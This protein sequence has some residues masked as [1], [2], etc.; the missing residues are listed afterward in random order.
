MLTEVDLC[1]R[2][3]QRDADNFKRDVVDSEKCI[4]NPDQYQ[5]EK[6][7]KY[8]K[9]KIYDQ[10]SALDRLRLLN[11]TF[12][13]KKRRLKSH[14]NQKEDTSIQFIKYHEVC[15]YLNNGLSDQD[16]RVCWNCWL[17]MIALYRFLIADAT[18]AKGKQETAHR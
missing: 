4:Y 13:N 5:A 7:V 3:L 9:G 12:L 18:K 6:L 14:I 11:K 10:E 2:D 17:T 16:A 1:I 8:F 15:L